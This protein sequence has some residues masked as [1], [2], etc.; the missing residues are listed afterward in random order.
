MRTTNQSL[1][2]VEAE[3]ATTGLYRL[4][5][6]AA[7]IAAGFAFIQIA[8][9]FIGVGIMHIEIPTTILGWFMLLQNHWLLGL[10]ALTLFQIPVFIFCIPVFQALYDALKQIN[11]ALVTVSTVLAFLGIAIYISSNTVF[12]MLSLSRQYAAATTEVQK[13]IFLAAGQAMLAI[14]EGVGVDIGLSLFMISI[15]LVS[16]IMLRSEIFKRA[17]A[18]VGILAGVIVIAYYIV[19]AFTPQA[20]FILEIAGLFF[21]AWLILVGQRLLQVRYRK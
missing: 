12:S 14:Y 7:L 15:L 21:V 17:S 20:I 2:N 4:G 9:E 18:Y 3:S 16:G 13:S 5:G 19:S 10:T 1:N 11:K 6:V 8:I